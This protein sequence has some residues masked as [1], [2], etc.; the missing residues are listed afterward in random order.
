MNH[1]ASILLVTAESDTAALVNEA[2]MQ[3]A[4]FRVD[5]VC[6]DL[7]DLA[8]RLERHTSSAVIVDIDP[9]PERMLDEL[10]LVTG[11]FPDVRFVVVSGTLRNEW[12]LAA[13][14]AGARHYLVKSSVAAELPDVIERVVPNGSAG[15]Q[16]TGSVITV[17]SSGGGCGATT[18][19]VNL[20][21]ELRI[22]EE[23]STL[24][25]DLDCCYGS[26]ATHLGVEGMYGLAEVLRG[27]RPVDGELI[28]STVVQGN[29][30][31]DLLMSPASLHPSEPPGLDFSLLPTLLRACREQYAHIVVDAPRVPIDVAADSAMTSH[32]TLLVFQVNVRDL[33][34]ARS[35]MTALMQRGV[36]AE[37]IQ[38]VANRYRRRYSLI[39]LN[40]AQRALDERT[41]DTLSNDYHSAQQS[42]NYGQLLAECAARSSLRRD[43]HK[44]ARQL[45]ESRQA[46][47]GNGLVRGMR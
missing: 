5:G 18:V 11:R 45:L 13:M 12:I 41:I 17:L 20:A 47:L 23:Q 29:D 26:A 22:L 36:P 35:T 44:F 4:T 37:T 27:D 3:R 21:N 19:A 42:L 30:G 15:Y 46:A 33:H 10:S 31:P 16:A 32:A 7:N 40:D 1:G 2:I 43:I 28:R 6:D 39:S 24:L 38:L 25:V 8:L 14:Q 34:I 9:S